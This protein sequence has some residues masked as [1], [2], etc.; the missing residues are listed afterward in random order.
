MAASHGL[1]SAKSLFFFHDHLCSRF[2]LVSLFRVQ[3]R[4]GDEKELV[5]FY[6]A[7]KRAAFWQIYCWQLQ[8]LCNFVKETASRK[9]VE[10]LATRSPLFFFISLSK[11]GKRTC[12]K[13]IRYCCRGI[14]SGNVLVCFLYSLFVVVVVLFCFLLAFFCCLLC[15]RRS[16]SRPFKPPMSRDLKESNAIPLVF[17][18][19]RGKTIPVGACGPG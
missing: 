5:E 16:M 3:R 19:K 12:C 7:E 15:P 11:G 13:M 1:V 4:W 17:L 8:G 14:R 2:L 10:T 6:S 18:L 9:K